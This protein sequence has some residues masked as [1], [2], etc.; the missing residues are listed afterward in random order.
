MKI[1]IEEVWEFN[2]FI[3]DPYYE[4]YLLNT[5]NGTKLNRKIFSFD[6]SATEGIYEQIHNKQN[7]I[8]YAM[9][10]EKRT[11]NKNQIIYEKEI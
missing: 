9:T 4:V 8:K 11:I 7:A 10:L 5:K 1:I 6:P 2:E 3:P